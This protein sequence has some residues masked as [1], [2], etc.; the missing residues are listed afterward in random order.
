[1]KQTPRIA[2][3]LPGCL[4]LLL[5]SQC[6]HLPF[7]SHV[8][9][10]KQLAVTTETTP[11]E[12]QK[13]GSSEESA[14]D[15]AEA[16][17]PVAVSPA[18]ATDDSIIWF[19]QSDSNLALDTSASVKGQSPIAGKQVRILLSR[20]VHR[21]VFYMLDSVLIRA[22]KGN[23][24]WTGLGRVAIETDKRTGR[25]IVI[26]SARPNRRF[27]TALPCTLKTLV[28]SSY[29]EYEDKS[30]RGS[31]IVTAE[32]SAAF[33]V[34]NALDIEEYLR[35]VVPL[36]IGKRSLKEIEAVKAQ[37][38]AARTY[39]C[40]R[41]L[42][43]ATADWDMLATVADQVYGGVQVE[44]PLCDMALR[45]TRGVILTWRDEPIQAYYHSTCGGRTAAVEDVW[46]KAPQPYLKSI[47]DTDSHGRAWCDLSGSFTWEEKWSGAQFSSVC[48]KYGR[49]SFPA[50]QQFAGMITEMKIIQRFGC[51][52]VAR[53]RVESTGSTVSYGGDKIR[54]VFR[55]PLEDSPILKSANFEIV[56]AGR[57]GVVLRGYGYG[58]GVGM[59]QMG[60][61][62]RAAQGQ[63]FQQILLDYYQSAELSILPAVGTS[64]PTGRGDTF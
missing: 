40:R 64:K 63:T 4:C 43:H 36:E 32:G 25:S 31:V 13:T 15:F 17:A 2:F 5:I 23:G 6:S 1:M 47:R 14:L 30:F 55:R 58:H 45:A 20:A 26:E 38:V 12:R 11:S 56:S 18:E 54:F 9:S 48:A 33:N 57:S 21:A 61:I 22:D 62:G 8:P 52:R 24:A 3:Q 34:V 59:C 50:T 49:T 19:A 41:M 51:G 16:F 39:T 60:A 35:G 10:E 46:N 28:R 7:L 29:F 37:A 44:Q 42:D 27:R 53:C